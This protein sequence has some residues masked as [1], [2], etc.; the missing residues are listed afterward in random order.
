MALRLRGSTSGYA[1]IDAPAV[2]GDVTLTLPSTTGTINVKDAG[3]TTN[4]GTGVNLGNP[5][6]NIFTISNT[7]GERLRIAADGTVSIPGALNVSGVLTYEDVTSVDAIGLSTFRDG[8]NTKDVGITT[9]SSSITDTAVDVLIYD[10]S[11]DSDGGAWRKRTTHTS[12]YNET[13]NT[14]TRGSRREFPSVAVIVAESNQVT[15]YDGD[16]PDLPMWMVFPPLGYLTWASNATASISSV[17]MLNGI[18]VA[19]GTAG[20]SGTYSDF[21]KDDTRYIYSSAYYNPVDR[22]I[23]GR[24]VTVNAVPGGGYIAG[25]DGF[26]ILNNSIN[27]VAMT[28]L[29]NAPIDDATGL[30]IPTIAV[31]NDGGVSVIKDDGNVYNY[32]RGGATEFAGSV[33]FDESND[34]IISWGT[35]SGGYRHITRITNLSSSTSSLDSTYG[36]IATDGGLGSSAAGGVTGVVKID[37]IGRHFGIDYDS[38]GGGNTDDRLGFLHLNASDTSKSLV[39][40]ATISYNTGWMHGDIKGAFLSDTDTTNVTGSEL[41]T[42]GTFDSD[43]SGWSASASGN[44]TTISRHVDGSGNTSLRV[45]SDTS[46]YGSAV[47]QV[48]LESNTTYVLSYYLRSTG[49]TTAYY[50]RTGYG[51][52]PNGSYYTNIHGDNSATYGAQNTFIFTTGTITG[53]QYLKLASR[54]DGTDF[55]YDNISLRKAELDRS[56]NNN[57][58]QV[59]GTITKSAVATGAELVAYSGFSNSNYLFQPS[60]VM[61]L[62]GAHSFIVWFKTTGVSEIIIHHGERANNKLRSLF[63]D[64]NGKLNYATYYADLAG[65]SDVNNGNWHCGVGVYDGSS[66][67]VYVDGKLE[68]TSTL[69]PASFTDIGTYIGANSDGVQLFTGDLALLRVSA[70][71]PSAEQIKKMYEDEK[72]LFQENAKATLYGSSDA[73][74]ALA[75]DEVTDQLHVGTSSGRSD[76]QGLR[77]INNT[78]TAV[79]TAISAHDSFILEQ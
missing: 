77:R 52:D 59:F 71:V 14:S 74:T 50:A 5:S 75:Y 44:G 54:N 37:N 41:I 18:L 67:K 10:T 57:G 51:T 31:A 30:L 29:P 9:I 61:D 45:V 79:T 62:S 36:Y 58:L 3:G 7:G 64:N 33:A 6:A 39:A 2:A 12:W 19:G 13:L 46:T 23:A 4:V 43:V 22:T 1:E 11:K 48:A 68:S 65:T 47:T 72:V 78:T 63:I 38:A 8:L 73:V 35:S 15:I 70:S 66:F 60:G 21:I 55:R 53:T 49:G 16:D 27:D 17:H 56:V 34:L 20:R 26:V 32:Y 42:N 25:G 24:N 40:F 28:V 76:F 69:S